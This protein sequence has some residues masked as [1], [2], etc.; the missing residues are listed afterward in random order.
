MVAAPAETQ[1]V[2]WRELS[3]EDLLDLLATAP[4]TLWCRGEDG[5]L[6]VAG[7]RFASAQDVADFYEKL[8]FITKVT[9]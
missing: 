3:A 4:N 6:K 8:G 2:M 7:R 9:S 5:R 1:Y